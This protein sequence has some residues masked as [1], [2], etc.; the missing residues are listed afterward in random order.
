MKLRGRDLVLAM[1][2]ALPM[3][4]QVVPVFN[5]RETDLLMRQW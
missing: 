5:F 4:P 2:A 3:L 1:M